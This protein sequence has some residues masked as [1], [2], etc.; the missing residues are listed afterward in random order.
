MLWEYLL[1]GGARGD[2]LRDAR[3]VSNAPHAGTSDFSGGCLLGV[4]TRKRG[5]SF[6]A[7]TPVFPV[8]ELGG[9]EPPTSSMPRKRAPSAPQPRV[10][11]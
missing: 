4:W 2:D 11:R 10:Q 1:Q 3:R 7:E 5:F 6:F 8:V 9:L